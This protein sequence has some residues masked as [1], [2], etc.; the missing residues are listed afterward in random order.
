LDAAQYTDD[1]QVAYSA[2]LPTVHI[3]NWDGIKAVDKAS[4]HTVMLANQYSVDPN[5]V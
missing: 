5:V 2:N 3:Q 4:I 1:Q